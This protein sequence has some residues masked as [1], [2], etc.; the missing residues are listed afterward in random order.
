MVINLITLM[1]TV[2][3]SNLFLHQF[4]QE[5]GYCYIIQRH[6]KN[7]VYTAIIG[8]LVLSHGIPYGNPTIKSI[9]MITAIVYWEYS[10]EEKFTNFT[11]LEAFMNVFLHFLFQPEFLY[12]RL[13]ELQKFSR[14]LWQRR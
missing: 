7:C 1:R 12:M 8:I 6:F 5:Y 9:I 4:L 13:P 10:V 3:L 11:N 14:E 2:E